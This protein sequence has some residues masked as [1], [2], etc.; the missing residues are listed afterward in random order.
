MKRSM[1]FLSLCLLTLF[2][3]FLKAKDFP[4]NNDPSV[5]AATGKVITGKDK[6]GNTKFKV[7]VRHLAEPASL[8][9]PK[10]LYVVWVQPKEGPP[11]NVGKLEV[12]KNLEGTLE[13]PTSHREFD[14]FITAED[15]ANVQAPSG[16]QLLHGTVGP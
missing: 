1:L 5:P 16:A 7:E 15:A 2:S 11:E 9:P 8:T 14:I 13:A 6:N 3:G 4:L 10:Q 12:N